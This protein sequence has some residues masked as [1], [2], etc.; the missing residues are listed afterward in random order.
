MMPAAPFAIS[1]A[2]VRIAVRLTPRSSSDRILGVEQDAAGVSA[3]KIAVTAAP[4]DGRAN[5]ALLRLLAKKLRL[6][7]RDFEIFRGA[8]SR[9][10]LVTVAGEPA[11]TFKR[12]EEG[13]RPWLTPE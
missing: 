4:E 9:H 8:A 2:A 7:R 6:P 1:G 3:L 11:I 12:V 5:E 10:K 13:L